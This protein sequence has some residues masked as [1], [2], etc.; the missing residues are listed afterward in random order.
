MTRSRIIWCDN[1]V[2]GRGH[3]WNTRDWKCCNNQPVWA[4][5]RSI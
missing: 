2:V 1:V 4:A 5:E 3:T